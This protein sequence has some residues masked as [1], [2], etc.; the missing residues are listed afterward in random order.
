[1]I[2]AVDSRMILNLVSAFRISRT[3]PS[4]LSDHL[5]PFAM[6]WLPPAQTTMEIPSPQVSRTVGGPAFRCDYTLPA[7]SLLVVVLDAGAELKILGANRLDG[8]IMAIPA[9]VE[10]SVYVRTDL[11]K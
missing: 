5:P 2:Y 7:A 8:A 11:A 9:L 6:Y 4:R 1:V 3:S 10:G